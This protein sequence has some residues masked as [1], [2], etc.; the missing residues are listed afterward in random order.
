M[1]V[2]NFAWADLPALVDFINLV[3]DV[4][5]EEDEVSLESLKE[6]LGQPGLVPEAN[7]CL[8]EEDRGLLAYYIL[9]P[10]V[11]ICRAVLELGI[12]PHRKRSDTEK[13]VVGSALAGAKEL[14]SRVLHICVAA[15]GSMGHLLEVEGFSRIRTYRVM[16]WQGR[17][18]PP[19][20]LPPGFAIESF[21]PGDDG[22]LTEAQNASFGGSWGFCPN[23][24]EEVRYR[25]GMTGST[26]E[27]ILFLIHGDDTAGYCWT[28]TIGNPE[29]PTGVIGMIGITPSYRG[30]RLSHPILLAGMKYLHS[31]GVKYIKLDVDDQNTPALKLYGSVGF[32]TATAIHWFEALLSES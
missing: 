20:E 24:V 27:G 12:H 3:R 15:S 23:T 22:R 2:R 25:A 32:E 4:G 8:F 18:V 14:G 17:E 28:R 26:P 6:E 1:T 11:R 7:C 29:H 13:E 19:M 9:H 21:R 31:R 5:G 16:R 10:E 30:R